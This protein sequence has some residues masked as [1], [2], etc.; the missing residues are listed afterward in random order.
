MA[1]ERAGQATGALQAE[2]MGRELGSRRNEIS[3][4]LNSM[5]GM[6]TADQEASLRQQLGLL[7]NSI[8]QQQVGLGRMGAGTDLMRALFQ[9][10][11]AQAGTGLDFLRTGLQNKQFYSGLGSEED[12]FAADLGFRREDRGSYWDAIRRGLLR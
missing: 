8:A 12:R 9:N 11:Q 6:L 7:D 1:S 3:Q 4:A 5:S 2:L 10:Q